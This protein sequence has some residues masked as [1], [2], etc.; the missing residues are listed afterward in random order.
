MK[1]DKFLE[2][3]LQ[4]VMVVIGVFLGMMAS[5]WSK[6]R[7]LESDTLNVIKG[8]RN[9]IQTN[10]DYL[11]NRK[12][13]DL[14]PFF[15]ALD[16]LSNALENQPMVLNEK[17]KEKSF[18]ERIP[19]FPGLGRPQLDNSMFETTKYS[20][21]LTHFDIELL[22]QLTKTYNLQYNIDATQKVLVQNLLNIDSNTVY[23]DVVDMMWDI[24][25][26]YFGAQYNLIRQYEKTLELIDA[27]L[28]GK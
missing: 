6:S 20:N 21:L 22:E 27:T 15:D 11:S 14:I 7:S 28:I 1:K 16:S 17:F 25:Q 19:M 2:Y 8:L 5:E 26:D 12:E 13:K 3:F 23:R 9:E 10:L 24:M 4:F 18:Q